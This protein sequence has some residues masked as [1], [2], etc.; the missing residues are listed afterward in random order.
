M[1]SQLLWRRAMERVLFIEPNSEPSTPIQG[2][3]AGL[4]FVRRSCFAAVNVSQATI[5]ALAIIRLPTEAQLAHSSFA[6]LPPKPC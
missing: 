3:S 6:L 5:D 2:A 4:P 1:D